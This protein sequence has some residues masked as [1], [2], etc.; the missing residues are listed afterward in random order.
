MHC[1]IGM[2]YR[3]NNYVLR[4]MFFVICV[5][6]LNHLYTSEL[7]LERIVKI[8]EIQPTELP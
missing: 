8:T 7:L 6:F 1:F 4:R 5:P 2:Q 3:N